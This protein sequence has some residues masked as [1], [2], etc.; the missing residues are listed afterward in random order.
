MSSVGGTHDLGLGV[1]E[2]IASAPVAP[3]GP[4][5]AAR[6]GTVMDVWNRFH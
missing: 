6:H 2:P 3:P 5:R 4:D 1:V